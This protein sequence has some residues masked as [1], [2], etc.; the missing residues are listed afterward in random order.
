MFVDFFFK[1]LKVKK[2]SAKCS[3]VSR[4]TYRLLHI[5]KNTF[6]TNVTEIEL[7]FKLN[8]KNDGPPHTSVIIFFGKN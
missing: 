5:I 1:L 4:E 7:I 8:L 3:D 2:L 6:Q